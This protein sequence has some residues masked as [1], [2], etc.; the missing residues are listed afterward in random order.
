MGG[1][2]EWGKAATAM[3]QSKNL[4]VAKKWLFIRQLFTSHMSQHFLPYLKDVAF[5]V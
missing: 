4:T 2:G 5:C 3:K 1:F